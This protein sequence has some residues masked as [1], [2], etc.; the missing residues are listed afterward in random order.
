MS[1]KKDKPKDAE[2]VEARS[3]DDR[4][5]DADPIEFTS[6]PE[7]DDPTSLAGDFVDEDGNGVDDREEK[8]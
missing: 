2:P 5:K 6:H 8:A 1:D 7:D 4:L 3:A